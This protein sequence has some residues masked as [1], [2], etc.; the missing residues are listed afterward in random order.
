MPTL[1]YEIRFAFPVVNVIS[2]V[3]FPLSMRKRQYFHLN[4]Y[5]ERSKRAFDKRHHQP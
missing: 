5:I 1:T 3:L 4:G 2:R